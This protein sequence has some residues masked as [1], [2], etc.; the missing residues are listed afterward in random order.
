MQEGDEID[1]HMQQVCN[2]LP[3]AIS[4]ICRLMAHIGRRVSREAIRTSLGAEGVIRLLSLFGTGMDL[5]FKTL[6]LEGL[7]F[8]FKRG[9]IW[10]L[11]LR[12]IHKLDIIQEFLTQKSIALRRYPT[13]SCS[14]TASVVRILKE[15]KKVFIMYKALETKLLPRRRV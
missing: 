9:Q 5:V 12:Q 8:V 14:K 7:Y 1:V 13:R 6:T 3:L 15:R 10:Y 4:D 2:L 11:L